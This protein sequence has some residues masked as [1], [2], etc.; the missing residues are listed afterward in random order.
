VRGGMPKRET[1]PIAQMQNAQSVALQLEKV[2]DKLPL[3]Y[4]RDDT[5]LTMI[6]QRG[7]VERVSSC[8]T[9]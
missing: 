3:L 5:L 1:N 6:Q 7:D 2:R 9:S 8:V 4:G